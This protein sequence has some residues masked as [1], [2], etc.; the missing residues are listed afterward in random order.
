MTSGQSVTEYAIVIAL[1]AL[2]VVL[3]LSWVGP[4]LNELVSE[5]AGVAR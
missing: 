1:V 3:A 2:A 4:A 5:L